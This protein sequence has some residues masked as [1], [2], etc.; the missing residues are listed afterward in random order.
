MHVIR[1]ASSLLGLVVLAST[2][3]ACGET[4]QKLKLYKLGM[5]EEDWP[6]IRED[7]RRP[8]E[9][10]NPAALR[11]MAERERAVEAPATFG[12]DLNVIDIFDM[13]IEPRRKGAIAAADPAPPPRPEMAD[14]EGV[15][16][17]AETDLIEDMT[18]TSAVSA[19]KGTTYYDP[20]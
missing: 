15:A 7:K 13:K 9:Q 12:D 17:E 2:L 10:P 8:V 3:S 5:V 6:R 11:Q 19:T 14:E 16:A 1:L 4:A 18:E 20:L